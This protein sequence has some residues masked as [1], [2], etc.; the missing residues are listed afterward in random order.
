MAVLCSFSKT[1]EGEVEE[2]EALEKELGVVLLAVK[3][4]DLKTAEGLTEDKVNKI[5]ALEKKLGVVLLA[6]Q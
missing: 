3:C 5:K 1:G 4:P 6:M 2:I